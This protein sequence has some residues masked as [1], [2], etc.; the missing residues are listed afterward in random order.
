MA[1]SGLPARLTWLTAGFPRPCFVDRESAAGQGH[2]VEGVHGTVR[3]AV[4]RHL[5]EAKTPRTTGLAI[6]HDPDRLDRARGFEELA[7]VPLRRGKSQVA[8]KNVHVWFSRVRVQTGAP[9]SHRLP[10][11][12]GCTTARR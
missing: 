11:S 4:V 3:C 10:T 12:H 2:A 7:E 9:V 8:H 5:D 1:V 6:G